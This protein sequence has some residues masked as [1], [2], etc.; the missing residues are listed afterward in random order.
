MHAI[1]KS[2]D[3][4]PSHTRHRHRRSLKHPLP[5]RAPVIPR[6]VVSPHRFLPFHSAPVVYAPSN[7]IEHQAMPPKIPGVWGLAPIRESK[8][9]RFFDQ[10]Y[11]PKSRPSLIP[12]PSPP[13]FAATFSGMVSLS[14]RTKGEKGASLRALGL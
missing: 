6:E 4:G 13:S 5:H 9:L 2:D 10:P 14:A 8:N 7:S 12:S 11:C 3:N 1:K